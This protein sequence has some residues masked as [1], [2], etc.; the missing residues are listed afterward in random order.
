MKTSVERDERVMTILANALQKPPAEREPYMRMACNNDED[1][2]REVVEAMEWEARMGSFLLEPWVEFAK[3]A[4]PFQAGQ[5]IEERFEIVREIGEG[6]MGIVYE[7]FDRKRDL[8]IAIK[9]AKPGFQRLLSPELEGALKVRHHNICLV[10]QIHTAQTEYGEI[11]F[12]TMEFLDGETLSA[13]LK[14][15]GKLPE[16]EALEI[17][18]QLCAGLAEAHRSGVIH[19]DLK[20]ANV[21]L[22][23]DRDGSVRAVIT[24]FGLAGGD[25]EASVLA[26]TPRYIAPEIWQ[27]KPASKASDIYALGMILYDMVRGLNADTPVSKEELVQTIPPPPD[28]IAHGLST[29]WARTIVHC[30]DPSAAAR[31]RDATAV[32]SGLERRPLKF[33]P[34][35]AIP[36]LALTTLVSSPVRSWLHDQIWPPPGVRLVVLPPSGSD[37][38]AVTSGGVLQDVSDRI[39]H[40]R[41][42]SRSVAV[43]PPG[44]A[45]DLQVQTPE[46]AQKVLHATHALQT[47]TQRQGDDIVVEGAIVDLETQTHVRN[48]SYRYS[49]QTVGALADALAGEVSAGLG[50]RGSSVADTLSAVAATPYDRGGQD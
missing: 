38:T 9:A 4:R 22:C 15:R 10:N 28:T 3:L 34:L 36:L 41:S 6:G 39:S 16:A 7:A 42:G 24:D 27:G 21:I 43:I 49:A 37:A 17:A 1:L 31:P 19:R 32:L 40:L 46:Q 13:R 48:F 12:L 33:M 5:V 23:R 2:Y 29:R 30:L 50:L 26:G 20:S 35:L 47:Q 45:L 11:D 18:R 8:K 14:A 25:T 44:K